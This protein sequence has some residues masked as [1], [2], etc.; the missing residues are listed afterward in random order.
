MP[1]VHVDDPRATT[2]NSFQLARL[3]DKSFIKECQHRIDTEIQHIKARKH[4]ELNHALR[5]SPELFANINITGLKRLIDKAIPVYAIRART[6]KLLWHQRSG[7]PCNK[8]LHNAH[9]FIT[10]VPKFD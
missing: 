8:H 1:D 9:K 4:I 5:S 3:K 10:G 2:R 6:E 7:H